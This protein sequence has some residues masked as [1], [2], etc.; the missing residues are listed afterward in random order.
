MNNC[1]F[2]L[3]GKVSIFEIELYRFDS[4]KVLYKK[5]YRKKSVGME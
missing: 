1:T 3:I 4:Y 5:K 2:N